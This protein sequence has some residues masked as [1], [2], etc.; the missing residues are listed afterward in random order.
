ME[1]QPLVSIVI[2]TYNSEK[3]IAAALD[4]VYAQEYP[5]D[6]IEVIIIDDFSTD[7]TLKKAEEYRSKF[8]NFKILRKTSRKGAAASTNQ[9]ITESTG[10]IVCSID[11]DTIISKN[12]VKLAVQKF[13]DPDV[14]AVA[15]LIES[16]NS[17]N[18]WARFM[19]AELE[20]RYER[21][22]GKSVDH[23]STCGTAY[24]KEALLEVKGFDED[25]KYGYDND[26]S[27][28][29]TKKGYK[30][31]LLGDI[32]CKHHWKESLLGYLTQQFNVAYYRLLLIDKYSEKLRGDA[33]SGIKMLIQVPVTGLAVIIAIFNIKISLLLLLSILLMQAP[34]TIRVIKR[35]KDCSFLI[36]PFFL[37]LRNLTWLSA[38]IAY[39]FK[40]YYIMPKKL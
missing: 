31:Y 15:G 35:K 29:L 11:S 8:P 18:I 13:T 9:G 24:R 33:I 37:L 21:I 27:Y 6:K 36:F 2:P 7:A 1:T 14:G 38:S 28:K 4:A 12:W 19:G 23:V 22:K 34:Q 10:E 5:L 32:S 40:I 16:A 3:T 17:H 26:A 20:D 30:I 39:L 25:Y